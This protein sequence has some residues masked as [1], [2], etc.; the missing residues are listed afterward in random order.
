MRKTW[1]V[2]MLI[3]SI[4]SMLYQQNVMAQAA[5]APV[6]NYVVNRA[7]GGII[8]NRIAVAQGAAANDAIWLATAANDPVYKATMAG[9]GS[10]MTAANVASTALGV[11]LA[12]AGAP[13][14]LTVAAGLGV[15]A[16]GAYIAYDQTGQTN[17]SIQAQGS[18]N[19]F[20]VSNKPMVAPA[21]P[22]GTSSGNG[23]GIDL[24]VANGAN[25]YRSASSCLSG[26]PCYSLPAL[27]TG[28]L[29]MSVSVGN[30]TLVASNVQD[31]GKYYVMMTK[32]NLDY[33]SYGVTWTYEN[34]GSGFTYS[35]DGTPHWYVWIHEARQGCALPACNPDTDLPNYDRTYSTYPTGGQFATGSYPGVFPSLDA[36]VGAIGSDLK[37]A[38]VNPQLLAQIADKA[39]QQAAAQPGYTGLPYSVANPVT[40]A[41][42]ATW[43]AANPT[44][45]PTLDDLLRPAANPTTDT[46]GVPIS[47]TVQVQTTP[48]P[49][50]S[51]NSNVNVVNTPNVNIANSPRVDL[52]PDPGTPDP[53][54]ESTPTGSEILSPITSLFPELRTFQT[55][56]HAG[57]CPKPVFDLFG[58]SITMDSHCTIAEQHRATLAAVMMAVWL[59]VGL[60]ILLSA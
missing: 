41:D 3:F 40:V 28:T 46:S 51:G 45:A 22:G 15:V 54:L 44:V 50:P 39:W 42:V 13:V 35:D 23:Y 47:P 37:A 19:K 26:Q 38:K 20:V 1:K 7:I 16:L 11:G 30:Y 32:P 33:S 29:P 56:G 27:P 24:A 55:P 14:W 10:T 25:I 9:V 31:L 58:K 17:L 48:T 60:F 53:T 57:E 6:E 34:A 4:V 5:L 52:G 43:T 2:Y 36:A 49:T 18:G 8:A 59:L 12:I 21:W